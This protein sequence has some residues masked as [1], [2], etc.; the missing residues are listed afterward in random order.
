[1]RKNCHQVFHYYIKSNRKSN[2]FEPFSD[3]FDQAYSKFN[4]TLI[5]NQDSHNQR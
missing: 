1:M 3:L 2:E 5:D 4:E